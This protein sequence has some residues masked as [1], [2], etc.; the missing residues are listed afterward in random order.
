MPLAVGITEAELDTPDA[1]FESIDETF[2]MG[3]IIYKELYERLSPP[4]QEAVDAA[5]DEEA[6][7]RALDALEKAQIGW[8]TLSYAIA[9]GVIDHI[10][11]NMEIKKIKVI[12]RVQ[13]TGDTGTSEP[14]DH[15]HTV[16]IAAQENDLV[17]EEL[18]YPP[19]Q[20]HVE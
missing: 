11:S 5:E 17:F 18:D 3:L 15:K 16:D 19:G 14:S 1:D 12:E 20:G 8:K 4:L 10:K 6:E 9:K 13:I 7:Q 2:G